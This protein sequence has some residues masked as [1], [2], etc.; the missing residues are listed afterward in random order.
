MGLQDTCFFQ[1]QFE[2]VVTPIPSVIGD[3]L[4]SKDGNPLSVPGRHNN[5]IEFNASGQAV[6]QSADQAGFDINQGFAEVWINPGFNLV[7][8]QA[9]AAKDFIYFYDGLGG[10]IDLMNVLFQT[11]RTRWIINVNSAAVI[12]DSTAAGLDMTAGN[13]YWMGFRWEVTH[14]TKKRR[15]YLGD[16]NNPPVE[17]D[18][19][20]TAWNTDPWDVPVRFGSRPSGGVATD[21]ILDETIVYNDGS[22]ANTALI[23][24][25]Y[26][27]QGFGNRN[28]ANKYNFKE[29]EGLTCH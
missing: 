16:E 11:T 21:F 8:G 10:S 25:N 6:Y 12:F 17:V 9:P 26:N 4:D 23:L 2:T 13:W 22:D 7:N 24:A 20:N 27:N 29:H 3:D 18:S 14:A 1:N 15:I 19:D 5:G 28:I